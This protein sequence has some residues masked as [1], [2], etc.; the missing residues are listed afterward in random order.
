M[1]QI[2]IHIG[3]AK[4][5]STYIQSWLENHPRIYF[6]PVKIVD[7]FIWFESLSKSN[8]QRKN[9]S[10]IFAISNEYLLSWPG[11]I[12]SYG[13]KVISYDYKEYQNKLCKALKKD[14]PSS[15]ILIVTRGYSTVFKSLYAEH[16][17]NGGALTFKEAFE[18]KGFMSS[19]LDYSFIIDLYRS[20]FKKENILVL[21]FEMLETNPNQ[22]IH[23]IESFIGIEQHFIFT[24][25][26][27]NVSLSLKDQKNIFLF[28]RCVYYLLT[29]CPKFLKKKLY[30]TY[31]K[32]FKLLRRIIQNIPFTIGRK[33]KYD[34][35]IIERMRGKADILKNEILFIPYFKDYLIN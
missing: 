1:S 3:Y 35:E 5:G 32:K 27:I 19:A 30:S 7:G 24:S 25:H 29:P 34:D 6:Q 12:D 17:K 20:T 22:F 33:I 10:S 28:S 9:K 18:N 21:P 4:A 11:K 8:Q 14:F 2:L 26:K 15:K 13:G 16:L 23:T 31:V